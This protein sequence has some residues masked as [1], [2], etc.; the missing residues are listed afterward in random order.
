M[1]RT[2]IGLLGTWALALG[3]IA[4]KPQ[5]PLSELLLEP[6]DMMSKFATPKPHRAYRVLQDR[7]DR[8]LVELSNGLV[9]VA[10]ETHTAPIVSAQVWVKTGSIY[11]QEHTGAGLSHFL[12]HLI[13]GGSTTTRSEDQS[14]AILGA[15]GA[16]INAATS[17]DT[18][19][20]YVNTASAYTDQAVDLLSDWMQNSIITQK[21]YQRE[22]S[23]IQRE[24]E[25]G[26]GEPGRIMWKLTQQARYTTHPARHPTIGYLD[27]FMT[28]SRDEIYDFYKRM[29][30]PNNMVFVVVGD[31]D[32]QK[33]V[34]QIATAWAN[35]QRQPLPTV[36]FPIEANTTTPKELETV[37][38]ID[39][40]RLRLMWPATRLAGEGDYALD[41]LAG[42][43]GQGESSRLVRTVRDQQR[44]TN[45]INAYN[46]SF[47][48]G[49]GFFGI[50]A[51]IA[52]PPMEA[53]AQTTAPLW[54]KKHIEMAKQA[55]L[56]QVDQIITHGITP[57]ELAR[58]KRK[59]MAAVIY[60]AQSAQAIARRLASDL[61]GM[62]DPDY[63]T[64]YAQA[65]Q[66]VT[67]QE[68]KQAA[69][70]FLNPSALTSIT[71][72]PQGTDGKPLVLSRSDTPTNPDE[73]SQ[74]VDLDN[75]DLVQQ[76]LSKKAL[77]DSNRTIAIKTQPIKR[78]VLANGLRV[79]IGSS[80]VVPAVSMQ[81][82]QLGGSLA[83]PPDQ[84]GLVN[85]MAAM[86]FKGTQTRTAEQIATQIEDLG[87][88]LST[89]CGYNSVFS[90]AVCLKDD[91]P[92]MLEL[93]A[94]VTINPV[95]PADEWSKMKP[96]LL[97]GIDRQSDTWNGE[98]RQR[99]R[100]AYFGTHPWSTLPSGDRDVVE[101]LTDRDL[102][103]FHNHYIC[104]ADSVLVVFD[105]VQPKEVLDR[106]DQLFRSMP[107]YARH[108]FRPTEPIAAKAEVLRFKT[109]KPL[110][111][112]QIG[113][114][115]TSRRQSDDYPAL[116]VLSAV[117]SR[118]PSGWLEQELRGRGPGLV[119]AVGAGQF[120]GLVPGY[121]AM[122]FNSN[123]D[124]VNEALKR[125]MSVI[126]RIR[127]TLVDDASL[128]AA[129]AKVLTSEFLYKQSNSARAADSALNELY[130]LG[131]DE[132]E[133]FRQ[134]VS[135]L[136]AQQLQVAAKTYL[137]NPVTVVI[138]HQPPAP[139]EP[140]KPA[141]Q[142]TT[143]P[144]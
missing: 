86:R 17:L 96:R 14:S 127:N 26:Q 34:D 72:Q 36:R 118:F 119:Y 6:Q 21:E 106:I 52:V 7:P 44:L 49:K 79:L 25:M 134:K 98:L 51:Q 67:Q 73:P 33:V 130:E 104:G 114:G 65:I 43:L 47:P 74:Q 90:K 91:W 140:Q 66:S 10:A 133:H 87:A 82:Y 141:T 138:N 71:M 19:H 124:S 111:A 62:K 99:F 22:R 46:A 45:S 112:V 20:Y 115:P 117:L 81:I 78:Y 31:I 48:W 125:S 61:I 93:L 128:A 11:E 29:Y 75:A 132:P 28:I 76:F 54:R 129:K 24:F 80:N 116:T 9:V 8:L 32:R 38:D 68:V 2:I 37:A 53:G 18:V 70:K 1:L 88:H 122:L 137:T 109:N 113:F 50:D 110:A 12:E 84:A 144:R 126:D 5:S 64:H 60:D 103:D 55:I 27:E 108:P 58:A 56:E 15:I 123:P 42:I 100:S 120:T 83:D 16:Q 13:S 121:F 23:V 131:L 63:L 102:A 41:L 92:T 101:S 4:C 57:P 95:F 107:K 89:E 142:P 59:T 69:A 40:P 97:A 94:D 105:D 85:A 143:Q 136:N 77:S 30:V 35:A 39:K 3:L 135:A 139:E